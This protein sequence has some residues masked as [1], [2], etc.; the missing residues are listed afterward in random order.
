MGEEVVE[1]D[2]ENGIKKKEKRR[3]M[4]IEKK[5]GKRGR[6]IGKVDGVQKTR[7]MSKMNKT[8][9]EEILMDKGMEKVWSRMTH[10]RLRQMKITMNI[11]AKIF[12]IRKVLLKPR[13]VIST[14]MSVTMFQTTEDAMQVK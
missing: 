9:R 6:E 4:G 3:R 14:T 12:Q 8:E 13:T 1:V 10:L 11:L 2:L 7:I 5:R